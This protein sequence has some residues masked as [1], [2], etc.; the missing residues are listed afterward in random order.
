MLKGFVDNPENNMNVNVK[1]MVSIFEASHL[2]LEGEDILEKA[3]VVASIFL[4]NVYQYLD[5]EGGKEVHDALKLPFNLRV[6]CFNIRNHIHG[7]AKVSHS[8]LN[9]LKLAKLNCNMI[10]V[11]H[12]RELKDILRCICSVG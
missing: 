10:Q 8:N 2:A 1:A 12:Q 11:V 3:Q 4:K 5:V 6:E 7:Y 9:L